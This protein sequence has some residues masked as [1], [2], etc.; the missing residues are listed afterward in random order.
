MGHVLTPPGEK[1]LL[2]A[3][4]GAFFIVLSLIYL[5][6]FAIPAAKELLALDPARFF[7]GE[8]W[9]LLT[10]QFIHNSASHLLENTAALLLSVL[11]AFELGSRFTDYTA[12]YLSSGV[13]AILPLWLV[14]PFMALG[15]S[16]AVYGSFGFLSRASAKFKI[17]PYFLLAIVTLLTAANAAYMHYAAGQASKAIAQ[18]FLAHISGLLFGYYF[19][20]LVAR[21]RERYSARRMT[22]LRTLSAA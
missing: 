1:T 16:T 9:R 12:T 7:S 19:C 13:L 20:I 15:A 6:L 11:L 18:Q 10:Y 22:C 14:S 4:L 2:I 17:R 21:L 3:A 8:V 5:A